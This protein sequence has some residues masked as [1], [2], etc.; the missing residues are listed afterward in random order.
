MKIGIIERVIPGDDASFISK[1]PFEYLEE[2]D[3]FLV[4]PDSAI[5]A[6]TL[7]KNVE[8]S[9]FAW[10]KRN[11][12]ILRVTKEDGN[13]RIWCIKKK[14]P[15][16]TLAPK[17]FLTIPEVAELLRISPKTMYNQ[18]CHTTKKAFPIRPKRFGRLIR[19]DREDVLAYM[20]SL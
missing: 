1:Y 11:N 17:K 14:I 9:A 2:G 4:I 10:G 12:T 8:H 7:L 3:S 20:K 5:E 6:L 19:F 16:R 18:V 15:D 13:V